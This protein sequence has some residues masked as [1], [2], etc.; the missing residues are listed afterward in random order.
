MKVL[1]KKATCQCNWECHKGNQGPCSQPCLAH[2][3]LALLVEARD[4]LDCGGM[5][6][7]GMIEACDLT[8]PCLRCRLSEMVG[9]YA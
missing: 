2:H 7:S 3:P 5:L 4:R 6:P 1:H 9:N 8:T